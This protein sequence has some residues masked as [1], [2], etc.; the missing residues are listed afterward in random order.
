MALNGVVLVSVAT[1]IGAIFPTPGDDRAYP[2]FLPTYAATAAYHKVLPSAPADA[3]KWLV[4]VRRFA[5]GEYATALA[6]GDRLPD[7]R[8]DAVA[9]KL[10][11][12]TGLSEDYWKL[13]NLRVA[14]GQFTAELMRQ[15][16]ITIGRLDSRFQ[17]PSFDPLAKD[18]EEDPQSN[19]ISAA[20]TAA[21]FD[22]YHEGLKFGQGKNYIVS[23]GIWP[24]WDWKHKTPGAAFALPGMTN[25]GVDLA[26]ALTANPN[27]KVLVL[28][29]LYDLATPFFATES[30]MAHL[31]LGK[32]G[33][34]RIEMKY[35]PAGHMM[36]I[37]EPSLKAF[38]AD[39]ADF[40]DR[41]TK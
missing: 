40:I 8:R 16:R 28:N 17:G 22:W 9:K 18:A 41:Q 2:L 6:E 29:G 13:A 11:E 37:H 14:E 23:A 3:D 38:K 32:T 25:T 39:V 19:A 12:Y 34:G 24:K 20:F 36:Y 10:H 7:D 33:Q 31:N 4:E 21:F 5:A 15:H 26:H 27:L 30:M 1:D 35:Y